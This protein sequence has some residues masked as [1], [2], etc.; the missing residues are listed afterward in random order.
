METGLTIIYDNKHIP[1][2]ADELINDE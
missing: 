1:M 2:Y